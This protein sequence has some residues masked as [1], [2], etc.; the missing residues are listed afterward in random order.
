M[1][2]IDRLQIVEIDD[3]QARPFA[4]PGGA[5]AFALHRLQEAAPVVEFRQAV[6]IGQL[7]QPG[8]ALLHQRFQ[9]MR[10]IAHRLGHVG[11]RA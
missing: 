7:L 2:V 11:Q 10:M 8:S 9:K 6:V 5:V 1:A 3:E 4:G